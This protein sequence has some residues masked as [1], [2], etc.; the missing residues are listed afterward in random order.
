[1]PTLS[2]MNLIAPKSWEEFEE[3]TLDA[4]KI[5]WDNPD[6][7]RHG[8]NGQKQNGVDIYGDNYHFQFVGVQCKKY[9]MKLSK[10]T[11]E[12]EIKKAENF[13]PIIEV[14]YIATTNPTDVKLQKEVRLISKERKK[15]NKFLVDIYF[16]NDIV[17]ELLTNEKVFK[18]H[19]PQISI[20]TFQEKNYK[21]FFSLLDLSYFGTNLKHLTD[22]IFGEAGAMAQEDPRQIEIIASIV[23]S[24]C[25]ATCSENEQEDI[26]SALDI[27]LSY[28][29]TG[30]SDN[31]HWHNSDSNADLVAGKVKV[32]EHSLQNYELMVFKIGELLAIWDKYE[33]DKKKE[34]PI[35]KVFMKRLK[36]YLSKINN[37]KIPDSIKKCINDYEK[38]YEDIS[39][40]TIAND[41]YNLLRKL[42]IE[43]EFKNL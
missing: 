25:I 9:E 13:K 20:D 21:R 12:E 27:F 26:L 42:L 33:F 37:G 4:L 18:K 29:K 6:L 31:F 24:A 40:A 28:L 8:R 19:Y 5:K 2:N 10:K 3:I 41:V 14:F 17:Q 34:I 7:K 11:I 22:V 39:K 30:K 1:M 23:K 16:W 35:S 32:I 38:N 36:G 15:Q 43:S